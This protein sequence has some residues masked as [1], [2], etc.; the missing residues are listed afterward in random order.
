MLLCSTTSTLDL[1]GRHEELVHGAALSV[2]STVV[3]EMWQLTFVLPLAHL[4]I[5]NAALA[6]KLLV[7]VRFDRGETVVHRWLVVKIIRCVVVGGYLRSVHCLTLNS[8]IG[9]HEI[10]TVIENSI[11]R[12]LIPDEHTI[13]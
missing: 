11:S 13:L 3:I 5:W 6:H 7:E 9:H 1:D 8:L 2:V 10:N 4:T 12:Q